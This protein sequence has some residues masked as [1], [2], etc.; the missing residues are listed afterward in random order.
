MAKRRKKKGIFGDFEIESEKL[1]QSFHQ[2]LASVPEPP[3]SQITKR[4]KRH[5]IE[6]EERYRIIRSRI[7]KRL[8][9]RFIDDPAGRAAYIA[10]SMYSVLGKYKVRGP[11]LDW[12]HELRA[13]ETKLDANT[14]LK[15]ILHLAKRLRVRT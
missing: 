12:D 14:R 10:G 8:A 15:M 4:K 13:A 3:G 2:T 1:E 9:S 7:K 11:L 5:P 6:V